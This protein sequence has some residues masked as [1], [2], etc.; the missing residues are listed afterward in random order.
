[1]TNLP[2]PVVRFAPSPTGRLHIGNIRTALINW[3]FA[4]K[5]GG[6]FILRLDDTDRERSTE[7]FAL[8]IVEDLNWLGINPDFQAKQSE[9]F[10]KY[11]AAAAKLKE[12][13]VLYPCY[14]TPEEIE[15]RRKRLMARGLPPVYDRSALKLTAEEK[16][17]L[18]SQGKKPHWRFLLPNFAESPFETQRTEIKWDDVMCGEQTVDLASM[19][20]PVLIRGDGTYLYTLPSVVDDLDMGV[21]HVI[22]GGDHI[23]NTGAQIAIFEAVGGRSPIFGHHNLLTSADGEGLSKRK[24]A[25]SLASLREDGLEPM[26]VASLATLIGTGQAV[27]ACD[28]LKTLAETFDPSKVTRSAAKFDAADLVRLNE[29]LLHNLAYDDAK[30]RLVAL[31]ADLGDAFWEAVRPNLSR[32]PDVRKW[33]AVVAGDFEPLAVE[34]EDEEFIKLASELLPPDPWGENV[35]QEWTS[36]LKEKTGRKGKALFM[37]LRKVL[38]GETHGPDLGQFLPVIG[39]EGTLHRLL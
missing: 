19:S 39:R 20:D 34:S 15:R 22:R 28:S 30:P 16:A 5:N 14:E 9:R 12:Q 37:P 4:K 36:A 8:G 32:F 2:E 29:A 26:A 1:M 33:S 24:G 31:N 35:W 11:D 23:T 18:E 3:L 13:R 17:E 25:L 6:S 10:E 27:E 38:T 7:E 21:T